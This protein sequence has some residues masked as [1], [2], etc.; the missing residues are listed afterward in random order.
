M[1]SVIF[2]R[3]KK[4]TL[5]LT[6]MICPEELAINLNNVRFKKLFECILNEDKK[7]VI[8]EEKTL[9]GHD[10][11][12]SFIM[13]LNKTQLVSGGIDETIKLWD[14]KNGKC[15]TDIDDK[16]NQIKCL[17][18]LNKTQ[19]A[20]GNFSNSIKIWDIKTNVCLKTLIGHTRVILSLVKMNKDVL[21]SGSW[22]ETIKIWDLPTTMPK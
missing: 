13:L 20:S 14:L 22:D 19:L 21:V 3:L 8:Y 7:K 4:K 18:K 12:V 11:I 6:L 2:S 1:L 17:A 5:S 15:I 16:T 10:Y 9:L